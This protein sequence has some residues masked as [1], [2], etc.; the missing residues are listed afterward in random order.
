MSLI[1]PCLLLVPGC[2][3]LAAR[4]RL[5][6]TTLFV[7]W[8]WMTAAW[9][10]WVITAGLM[11]TM[12]LSDAVRV[13]LWYWTAITA[14]CPGIAVLGAKR[15][16]SGV[17]TIFILVPLLFVLG[18]P[19]LTVWRADGPRMFAVETPVVVGLILVLVMGT[20][21]YLGT[22]FGWAAF[23]YALA[24]VALVT[25]VAAQAPAWA[26]RRWWG[27]PLPFTI[28]SSLLAIASLLASRRIIPAP[29]NGTTDSL[30]NAFREAFGVVWSRRLQERLNL[31]AAR[32][33]WR[34]RVGPFGLEWSENV[35]LD[36]RLRTEQRFLH[37]LRWLLR[38]FVDDD[39]IDRHLQARSVVSP[40]DRG[41][42]DR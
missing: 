27:V 35:G 23:V 29:E 32:E 18:W 1:V 41:S 24:V 15:P 38:R 20:G 8:G 28:A 7:A 10:L 36:D 12:P 19:A 17:W 25:P 13:Q 16:G 9:G 30:W 39:W 34:A 14:L 40:E 3:L 6:P 21:N 5:A 4:T 26:D 11:A 33:R 31:E 22:R 42:R 37:H 2:V